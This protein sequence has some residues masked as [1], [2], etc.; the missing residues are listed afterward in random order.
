MHGCVG[1][2]ELIETSYKVGKPNIDQRDLKRSD[3]RLEQSRSI[4][5]LL[6]GGCALGFE[7]V[8][9]IEH[10]DPSQDLALN[11]RIRWAVAP[12]LVLPF[13]SSLVYFV[14]WAGKPASMVLYT[15][16]KIFTVAWPLVA[17]VWIER[18]RFHFQPHDSKSHRRS[19]SIGVATGI[20]IAAAILLTVY[21]SPASDYVRNHAANILAKIN[22]FGL[23]TPA[24]FIAFAGFISLLHS[25][26]E[27]YYW[28]WYVFGRLTSIAPPLAAHLIAALGFAGHHYVV[29]WCYFS[30]AGAIFFGTMVAIGGL[31][32]S[33][34]YHRTGSLVGCWVSHFFV[35]VAIMIVGYRMAFA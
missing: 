5:C 2:Q 22:D 28:R 7:V 6:T 30:P 8:N 13:L 12:A 29:L 1:S 20:T 32:W 23:T 17:Y 15:A 25:A 33:T 9:Q 19:L 21:A 31:I 11:R 24:R 3:S 4:R 34:I 14:L 18:R 26:I 16:T 35:D 27:E 10:Q